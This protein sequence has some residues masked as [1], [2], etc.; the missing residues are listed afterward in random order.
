MSIYW[1]GSIETKRTWRTVRRPAWTLASLKTPSEHTDLLKRLNKKAKDW[2]LAGDYEEALKLMQGHRLP[3]SPR[4]L[5]EYP[6][7]EWLRSQWKTARDWFARRQAEDGTGYDDEEREED[8]RLRRVRDL[9]AKFMQS[10]IAEALPA[11]LSEEAGYVVEA[12]LSYGITHP[13]RRGGGVGRV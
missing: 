12:L 8:A 5:W 1:N 10:S 4:E 7:E 3:P 9:T 6:V 2:F 13:G 11:D